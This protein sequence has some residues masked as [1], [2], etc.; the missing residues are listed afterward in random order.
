[1]IIGKADAPHK[2]LVSIDLEHRLPLRQVPEDYFAVCTRRNH[3]SQIVPIFREAINAIRMR[4]QSIQK[5]LSKYLLQL[6]S[7]E[8]SLI[9]TSLLK[10]MKV[11]VSWISEHFLQ[12]GV[13]LLL[14][15]FFVP[16]Y[17]FDFDHLLG[18]FFV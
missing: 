2:S 10:R 7:V 18:V 4:V 12:G 14:I 5:R 16:T 6:G 1:M 13:R 15:S 8:S 11:R 9:F 3:I 17:S